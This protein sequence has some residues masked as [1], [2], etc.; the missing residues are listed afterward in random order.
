[1]I[2]SNATP[3][4]TFARI[5]RLDILEKVL[6]SILIPNAVYREIVDYDNDKPGFIDIDNRDWISIKSVQDEEM[7]Q[8]L[9]PA[10]D[11]G[12]AEVIVL[13]QEINARLVIMDELT[14]R[15][16]A[17]SLDFSITGS[18]G[19]LIKAKEI[20]FI[21]AVNPLLHEIRSSGVYFSQG[22]I[23]QVLQMLGEEI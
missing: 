4:I 23:N 18:F 10:L 15:K 7:V 6:G 11:R 2:V 13:A 19:I 21:E 9:I 16:V 22:F 20:G 1:M 5:N 3:L 14:G 17:E 8:M 12:E